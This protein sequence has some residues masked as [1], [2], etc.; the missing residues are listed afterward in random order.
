M[1]AIAQGLKGELIS[2]AGR[3]TVIL[4]PNRETLYLRYALVERSEGDLLFP[5][6]LMDDWGH[7]ITT[8][9]LYR[10][11]RENGIHFPRAEVFGYDRHGNSRQYFIRELDLQAKYG[12]FGFFHLETRL[13]EGVEIAVIVSAVDEPVLVDRKP[14]L[15]AIDWPLQN[16]AVEWWRV[17]SKNA[18]HFAQSL[19]LEK[20]G[21]PD[22]IE[23]S[24]KRGN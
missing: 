16:A 21:K 15:G 23:N 10:W 11:I 18:M 3:G 9:Q 8:L 12:C 6:L 20:A 7:E 2:A 1:K 24:N 13:E 5:E 19:L 14:D 17:E 4:D 22:E